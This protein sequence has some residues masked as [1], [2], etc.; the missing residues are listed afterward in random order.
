MNQS[1]ANQSIID[2]YSPW[3]DYGHHLPGKT[4][5]KFLEALW[6][7]SVPHFLHDKIFFPFLLF[8]DGSLVLTKLNI[9]A[10]NFVFVHHKTNEL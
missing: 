6:G 2:V 3:L 10:P 9:L 7:D 4:L 1:F 8:N 5:A